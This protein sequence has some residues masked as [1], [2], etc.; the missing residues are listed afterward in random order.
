M[1][2]L[3]H[4]VTTQCKVEKWEADSGDVRDAQTCV[5]TLAFMF[6]LLFSQVSDN[7]HR[8]SRPAQK[9]K[10]VTCVTNF[11][12]SGAD[13][14]ASRRRE[15]GIQIIA[16]DVLQLFWVAGWRRERIAK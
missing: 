8:I 10:A 15:F 12:N 3:L 11:M 2:D 1:V 14:G 9:G 5:R 6:S 7:C 4:P 13:C 16:L